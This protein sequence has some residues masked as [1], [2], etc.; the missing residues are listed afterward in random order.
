MF[1]GLAAIGGVLLTQKFTSLASVFD[2]K[3]LLAELIVAA[4]FGLTPSMLFGMLQ[5]QTEEYKADL[6]STAATQQAQK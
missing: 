5:K 6:K 2:P 3:N 1:S 4:V